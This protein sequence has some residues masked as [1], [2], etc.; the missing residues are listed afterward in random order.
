MTMKQYLSATLGLFLAF[1]S[2]AGL[3]YCY[4]S[5]S[6]DR[7][8]RVFFAVVAPTIVYFVP[9]LLLCAVVPKTAKLTKTDCAKCS[10]AGFKLS[11]W[12]G[13]ATACTFFLLRYAVAR[14]MGAESFSL[15]LT[16]FT[17][18]D[19]GISIG[20]ILLG[21][22][23]LP[24]IA[25]G[26]YLRGYLQKFLMQSFGTRAT[27]CFVA[28]FFAM[29]MGSAQNF[30][31]YF[32]AGI[33]FSWVAV[34]TGTVVASMVARI[35][36]G[37]LYTLFG[38]ILETFASYGIWHNF[39]SFAAWFALL[40]WYLALVCAHQMLKQEQLAPMLTRR[41]GQAAF[42]KLLSNVGTIAFLFA[43]IAKAVFGIM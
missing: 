6:N 19:E 26:I 29:L 43:F 12:L 28:V 37:L 42:V 9:L 10:F 24:A 40:F 20:W 17:P 31:G 32:I 27:I 7:F 14:S 1:C 4:Q 41:D 23:V 22:V 38:V 25:E 15:S 13:C 30:V 8:W 16:P 5:A 35:S 34:V 33:A 21:G 18:L 11:M 2:T 3:E 39:P 36:F